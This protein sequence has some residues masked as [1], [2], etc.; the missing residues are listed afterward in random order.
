[1]ERS[2]AETVRLWK[3]RPPAFLPELWKRVPYWEGPGLRGSQEPPS[4]FV[5]FCCHSLLEES[6]MSRVQGPG[7]P[8]PPSPVGSSRTLFPQ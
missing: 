2:A 8:V 6:S 1:M 4:D 7:K 5:S 3:R